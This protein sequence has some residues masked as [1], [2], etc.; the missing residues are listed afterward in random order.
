MGIGALRRHY[1]E[2]VTGSPEQPATLTETDEVSPQLANLAGEASGAPA[3]P[4]KV[5]EGVAGVEQTEAAPQAAVVEGIEAD[6]DGITTLP[7]DASTDDEDGSEDG[8]DDAGPAARPPL[9]GAGST[10]DAWA[11]YALA[12][13]LDSEQIDGLSRAEI[14]ALLPE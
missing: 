2:V 14:A 5:A 9:S 10:L 8:G 7:V 12:Q 11:A 4:A 1:A 6:A 3:A 13:G